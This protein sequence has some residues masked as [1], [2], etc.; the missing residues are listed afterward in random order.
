MLS[1]TVRGCA[2]ILALLVFLAPRATVGQEE[3]WKQKWNQVIA[4]AQ[5]EGRVVI[6]GPPDAP[7]RRELPAAFRER[8][9]I[10]LEYIGARGGENEARLSMERRAGVYTVDAVMGGL[11]NMINYYE[12][13][14]L[15]PLLPN[16]ILPEVLDPTK[17]KGGRLW[18]LDPENKYVLRLY[19]YITGG[20][21]AINTRYLSASELKSAKDLL[22]PKWRGKI[23]AYDPTIGGTG[24]NEAASY[25]RIFGEAFIRKLYID[26]KPGISRDKRQLMDW[27]AHGTYP[28]NLGGVETDGLM[29]LKEQGLPLQL[30]ILSDFP[31]TLSAGAGIVAIANRP[32]HPNAA[33]VFVNWIASKDGLGLLGRLRR[34]STTRNDIDESYALA[35][36]APQPDVKYFDTYTWE[37]NTVVLPKV[38]QLMADLLK[39]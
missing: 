34:K 32:P 28:I 13:K 8:F 25:Y 36:E 12:N 1:L 38:R 31:G 16:L 9:G 17:W 18:F 7:L 30:N 29:E 10:S 15:D 19:S 39:K 37:F 11:T 6:M 23:S 22:D 26:Q 24:Q 5:K 2:A 4:A 33:R 21:P 35:W 27:L 3:S 14:M 20:K